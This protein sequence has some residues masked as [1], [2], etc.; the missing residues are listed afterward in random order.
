M[1]SRKQALKELNALRSPLEK[2]IVTD[3]MTHAFGANKTVLK[4]EQCYLQDSKTVQ[5]M[6]IW[7]AARDCDGDVIMLE[8]E[9][10]EDVDG[11][12][13]EESK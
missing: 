6:E 8:P 5:L 10:K 3:T 4:T 2:Q 12:A 11:K 7:A 13:V 1:L 9:E